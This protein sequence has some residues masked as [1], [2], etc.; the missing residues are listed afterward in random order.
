MTSTAKMTVLEALPILLD[1]ASRWGE[2]FEE[3]FSERIDADMTD[4]QIKSL[5][6]PELDDLDEAIGL[7]NLWRALET[8][9]MICE[10]KGC[11]HFDPAVKEDGHLTTLMDVVIF[12]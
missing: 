10:Q 12:G 1:Y 3:N 9:R 2:N 8:I 4:E 6:D 11:E 5:I 7:R